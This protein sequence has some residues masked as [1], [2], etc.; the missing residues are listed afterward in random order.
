MVTPAARREAAT[1]FRDRYGLSERRACEL[2]RLSRS[3]YRYCSTLTENE[4]ELRERLQ[5]LARAQPRYGYRRL[6]ALLR[7]EGRQINQK[8]THRIYRELGLQVRRKPRKRPARANRQPR[9]VP[10]QPNEQWSMDFMADSLA[11]GRGFRTLNVLDD[12]LRECL[13]IEVDT[14]IPALRVCRVLDRL[15]EERGAPDRIVIDNGP[16]F[17]SAALDQWASRHGVELVFIRPGKPIENAFVESFNGKMRDE[18]LSMHWFTDL[19]DARRRIERW[20]REYNYVRPHSS[21]GDL[22]PVVA[23]QRAGLR[24]PPATSAPPPPPTRGASAEC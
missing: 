18:C 20:R 10:E 22:P 15:V 5:E 16:E 12:A 2:V 1:Y 11:D 13:A 14:S 7:R 4:T 23:A 6:H 9:A 19:A 21:L 8:R 24:P 17:T 3:T